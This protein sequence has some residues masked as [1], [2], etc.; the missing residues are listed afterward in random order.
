MAMCACNLSSGSGETGRSRQLAGLVGGLWAGE[1]PCL[2]NAG[3]METRRGPQCCLSS[4]SVR[5]PRQTLHTHTVTD[6]RVH[7]HKYTRKQDLKTP[8]KGTHNP[9]DQLEGTQPGPESGDSDI[10]L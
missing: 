10:P 7:T 5:V 3:K 9:S 1:R 6:S 2:K 8:H 4:T